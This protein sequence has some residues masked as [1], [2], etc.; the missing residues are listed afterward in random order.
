M[1]RKKVIYISGPITG[2]DRYWESFEAMED[3]I[4]ALGYT[5]LSPSRLPSGMSNAQYMRICLAMI[6]SADAVVFLKD[7][8]RSQGARLELDYCLYTNKPVSTDP[9]FLK[10]VLG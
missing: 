5:P 7:W 1:E 8:D 2:V 6:D 3:T 4:S 9:Y 10:G